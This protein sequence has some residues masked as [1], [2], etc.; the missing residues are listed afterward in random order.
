MK[1]SGLGKL[2][3]YS[4][5]DF[6]QVICLVCGGCNEKPKSYLSEF[7]SHLSGSVHHL[8]IKVEL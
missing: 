2:R 4:A 8:G 7:D 5:L 6:V 3:S 1:V